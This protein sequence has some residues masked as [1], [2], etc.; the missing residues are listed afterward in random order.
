MSLMRDM[1]SVL[2]SGA[3][4]VRVKSQSESARCESD[5]LSKSPYQ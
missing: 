2:D 5:T 3:L 4:T 1:A